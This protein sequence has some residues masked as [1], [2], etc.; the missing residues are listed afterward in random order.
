[1][2]RDPEGQDLES[3]AFGIAEPPYRAE[4]PEVKERKDRRRLRDISGPSHIPSQGDN[5]NIAL[6][7]PHITNPLTLVG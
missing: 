6:T 3:T 2:A 1:M 4:G 5:P 7:S